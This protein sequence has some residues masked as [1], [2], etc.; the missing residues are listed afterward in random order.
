MTISS[1]PFYP[2]AEK[3]MKQ[4]TYAISFCTSRWG[5]TPLHFGREAS[6]LELNMEGPAGTKDTEPGSSRPAGCSSGFLP[7]LLII[8]GAILLLCLLLPAL[9]GSHRSR[10]VVVI[11]NLRNIEIAKEMWA[12]DHSATG[13]VKVSAQDL[14]PY[15]KPLFFSNLLAR[16]VMSERYI[17]HPVGVPAQAQLI[18]LA[19]G[20]PAGTIICSHPTGNPPSRIV[21]P[22]QAIEPSLLRVPALETNKA[23]VPDATQ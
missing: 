3:S 4:A 15:L 9:S 20:F 23:V 7:F 2:G 10:V 6:R 22:K 13:G 21:R 18:R 11:N 16:P 14:A 8:L 1:T 17:I 19:R 5:R 12:H